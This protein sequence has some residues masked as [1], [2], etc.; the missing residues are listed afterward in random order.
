M[1]E[2][3]E[4]KP[5]NMILSDKQIVEKDYTNI[6]MEIFSLPNSMKEVRPLRQIEVRY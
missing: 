1:G 5:P 4:Y 3:I 6:I 2:K